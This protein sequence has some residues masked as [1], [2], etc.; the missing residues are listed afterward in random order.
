MLYCN[1]KSR[2][3]GISNLKSFGQL[4]GEQT[5]KEGSLLSHLMSELG[6]EDIA[7]FETDLTERQNQVLFEIATEIEDT[8][9]ALRQA[10]QLIQRLKKHLE[11][12]KDL[13]RVLSK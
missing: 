12:L 3:K 1:S 6:M 8:E 5:K 13:Q 11:Q 10:E 7:H 2:Q 9:D 4:D